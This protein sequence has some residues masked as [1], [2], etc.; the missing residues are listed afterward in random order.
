MN[1]LQQRVMK[2]P[3]P[4]IEGAYILVSFARKPDIPECKVETKLTLF[5]DLGEKGVEWE[6][7]YGPLRVWY[8][9]GAD[10]PDAKPHYFYDFTLNDGKWEWCQSEA[11]KLVLPLWRGEFEYVF[12]AMRYWGECQ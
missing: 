2:C 7:E 3:V 6:P 12:G 4:G 1:G 11:D 8:K 9:C 5:L 10:H